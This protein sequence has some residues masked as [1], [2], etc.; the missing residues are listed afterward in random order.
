MSKR[1]KDEIVKVRDDCNGDEVE[2]DVLCGVWLQNYKHVDSFNADC[3][4]S[5]KEAHH[6]G[7]FVTHESMSMIKRIFHQI[8]ASFD[9]ILL[10]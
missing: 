7:L 5:L 8:L 1:L 6:K 3:H 4:E 10:W 2:Y 9:L